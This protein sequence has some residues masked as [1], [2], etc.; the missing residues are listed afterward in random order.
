MKS[1]VAKPNFRASLYML[2]VLTFIVF[3]GTRNWDPLVFWIIMT[4]VII[5]LIISLISI[6]GNEKEIYITHPFIPFKKPVHISWEDIAMI[7]VHFTEP[8]ADMLKRS[9]F[10]IKLQNGKEIKKAFRI[11]K[12]EYEKLEE[13]ANDFNVQIERKGIVK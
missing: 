13:L 11:K 12:A 9:S 1:F 2:L 8:L 4:M 6:S 10:T 5:Y 3:V 7:K